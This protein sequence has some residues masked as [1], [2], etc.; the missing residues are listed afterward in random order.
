[1]IMKPEQEALLTS[2]VAFILEVR[3]RAGEFAGPADRDVAATIA[4]WPRAGEIREAA[5][6]AARANGYLVERVEGAEKLVLARPAGRAFDARALH[7]LGI[8]GLL[9]STQPFDAEALAGQIAGYLAGPA[10]ASCRHYVLDIDWR[11]PSTM[12]IAEWLLWRPRLDDWNSQRPIPAAADFAASPVFDPLLRSGEHLVLSAPDEQPRYTTGGLSPVRAAPSLTNPSS[13]VW[14]ALLAL[15]LW[16]NEPVSIVAEYLVEPGR[17]VERVYSEI[18]GRWLGPAGEIPKLGPLE[19]DGQQ[20]PLLVRFLEEL[21]PHLRK[22]SDAEGEKIAD[23]AIDR[24][25]R[26]ALSFLNTAGQVGYTNNVTRVEDQP[27]VLLDYVAALEILLSGG[28][29]STDRKRRTA[30]RTAV[31]V[32]KN[33]TQRGALCDLVSNA[34]TLRAA[35]AHDQEPDAKLLAIVVRRL[36]PTVRKALLNALVLG[37]A[38]PLGEFCDKAVLS[39]TVLEQQIRTPIAEFQ[40]TVRPGAPDADAG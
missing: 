40:K 27:Q 2:V 39:H 25:R 9:R 11:L 5:Q 36:R 21:V 22:W 14:K 19:V 3:E 10:G 6:A 18:P 7:A 31:L 30:Q 32:G 26:S 15:N 12:E 24:L 4:G 38:A 20:S 34:Y 37:P 1:M 29:H 16:H 13:Q 17:A 28:A 23:Q 8:A 35:I 33:D